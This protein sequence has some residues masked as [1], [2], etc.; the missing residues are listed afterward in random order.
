[1]EPITRRKALQL[2]GLITG[3]AALLS[4]VGPRPAQAAAQVS[5]Q[6]PTPY[7]LPFKCPP[8]ATPLKSNVPIAGSG[9]NSP[10]TPTGTFNGAIEPIG[11]TARDVYQIDIQ[12]SQIDILGN[13]QRT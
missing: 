12:R 8:L 7:T 13:G 9:F 11:S 2:A 6:I 1:M 3:E 10:Y 5:A 4:I